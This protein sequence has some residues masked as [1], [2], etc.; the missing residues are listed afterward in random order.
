[1]DY[2]DFN[3]IYICTL[4]N[5]LNINRDYGFLFQEMKS[6]LFYFKRSSSFFFFI[7]MS[8]SFSYKIS[9]NMYVTFFSFN[10][11]QK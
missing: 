4:E 3:F 1:M 10:M 7:Q 2:I 6:D 9:R 5:Y 11:K 8:S